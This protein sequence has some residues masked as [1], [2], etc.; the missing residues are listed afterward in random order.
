[1]VRRTW[2]RITSWSSRPRGPTSAPGDVGV[3]I[4]T[5]LDRQHRQ[6][7]IVT[8]PTAERA[9][10]G[11]P[12]V[13]HDAPV[14]DRIVGRAREPFGEQATRSVEVHEWSA[15][16]GVEDDDDVWIERFQVRGQRLRFGLAQRRGTATV[17]RAEVLSGEVAVQVDAVRVRPRAMFASVRVDVA[18][19][20][21]RRVSQETVDA[22]QLT[23]AID[24]LEPGTFVAVDPTDDVDASGA[25]PERGH[26][27]RTTLDALPDRVPLVRQRL[28]DGRGL[29]RGRCRTSTQ[30]CEDQDGAQHGG[31]CFHRPG[32]PSGL[33]LVSETLSRV[34][35]G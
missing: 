22:Q 28:S 27:D 35:T 17:G 6:A 2:I 18:Q 5:E 24:V 12:H 1:M 16:S 15:T 10:C 8:E 13:R 21:H 4:A 23:Q 20:A 34:R 9:R 3:L 7:A 33:I 25:G 26:L 32:T 29:Y 14:S 19:Q 11:V 31:S 30:E